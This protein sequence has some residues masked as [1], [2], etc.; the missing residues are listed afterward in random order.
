[1]ASEEM[2][3]ESWRRKFATDESMLRAEP[4]AG[5]RALA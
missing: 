2:R 3:R 5:P 4:N 1:M